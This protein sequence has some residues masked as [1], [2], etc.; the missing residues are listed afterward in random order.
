[1]VSATEDLDERL[2][3]AASVRRPE[4]AAQIAGPAGAFMA[5]AIFQ[6]LGVDAYRAALAGGPRAYFEAYDRAV[7]MRG[8][9]LIPVAQGIRDR[10]A[11]LPP[12]KPR[13]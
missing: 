11:G 1:M 12:P 3:L 7:A 9:Q 4:F 2:R 10:L 8:K 13:H 5:D 6:T